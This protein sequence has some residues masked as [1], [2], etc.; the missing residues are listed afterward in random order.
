LE[1]ACTQTGDPKVSIVPINVQMEANGC[2]GNP[3]T[4]TAIACVTITPP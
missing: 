3:P 2:L 4:C 1:N